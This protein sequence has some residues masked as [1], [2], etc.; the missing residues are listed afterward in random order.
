MDTLQTTKKYISKQIF[1]DKNTN[2]TNVSDEALVQMYVQGEDTLGTLYDRYKMMVYGT[3]LK[4]LKNTTDAHDAVSDIFES[5]CTKLAGQKIKN[6]KPWLYTVTRNHCIEILRKNQRVKEKYLKAYKS[7]TEE[8][9]HPD[10]IRDEQI[11]SVLNICIE[12]LPV[13]QKKTILH[14]YFDKKSYN[15]I[16][17]ILQLSWNKVRSFIQN[18]RRNLKSCIEKNN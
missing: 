1:L 15:E 3:C 6:F 2:L 5:L 7:Y 12:K 17:E 8:V 13:F 11:L 14:F 9:F 4:Y 10:E 16:A 18:G